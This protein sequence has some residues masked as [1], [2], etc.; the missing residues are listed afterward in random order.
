MFVVTF[1]VSCLLS[2]FIIIS[3]LFIFPENM[4]HTC[5]IHPDQSIYGCVKNNSTRVYL[6]KYL[7]YLSI[8]F[9]KAV[10]WGVCAKQLGRSCSTLSIPVNLLLFLY[11]SPFMDAVLYLSSFL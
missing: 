6:C 8:V 5:S 4:P 10:H 9:L 2:F 11:F 1:N 7:S 3:S